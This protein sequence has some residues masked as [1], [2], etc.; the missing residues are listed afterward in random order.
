MERYEEV[1]RDEYG[2]IGRRPVGYQEA[3][4][5]YDAIWAIALALNKTINQL[6]EINAS[7][8]DF[9]YDNQY[10]AQ[11]IYSAMNTTQFLGVS[12]S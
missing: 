10:I 11:Q 3:P 9:T 12:V 6:K 8:E 1:L 2:Y 5:A 4:L 7:I